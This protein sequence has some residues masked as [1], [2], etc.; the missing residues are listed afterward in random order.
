MGVMGVV[1]P[2]LAFLA[3]IDSAWQVL[4]QFG[5]ATPS[6]STCPCS[7]FYRLW[8]P[9]NA[10]HGRVRSVFSLNPQRNI[11]NSRSVIRHQ[12]EKSDI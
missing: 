9:T 6:I 3:R 12:V 1:R 2:R 10:V 7:C 11:S 5:V 4:Y 8:Q